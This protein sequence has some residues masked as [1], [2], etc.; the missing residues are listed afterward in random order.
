MQILTIVNVF[1]QFVQFPL[2]SHE[3]KFVTFKMQFIFIN[4]RKNK[5]SFKALFMWSYSCWF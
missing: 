1:S 2:N 4:C 5:E 3:Y